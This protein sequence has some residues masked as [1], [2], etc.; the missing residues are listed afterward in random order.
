MTFVTS[1]L[2]TAVKGSPPLTD[3]PA[4]RQA[5]RV[6]LRAAGRT[7]QQLA[8]EMGLHPDVLS[9]KINGRD[10]S[11]L[12]ARDAV[13]LIA[14]LAAWGAISTQREADDLLRLG[15]VPTQLVSTQPW[16]VA[17]TVSPVRRPPDARR[18]TG[19]SWATRSGPRRRPV[20]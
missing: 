9:H 16:Y 2:L 19:P 1:A 13:A 3:L 20:R 12:T 15:A 6:K 5:V 7:Q 18:G 10:G 14:T 11:V 4:F 8:R 17:L